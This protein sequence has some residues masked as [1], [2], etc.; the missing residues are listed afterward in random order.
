[1]PYFLCLDID[2]CAESLDDCDD[3]GR[4]CINTYGGYYCLD[5]VER[6]Y[7]SGPVLVPETYYRPYITHGRWWVSRTGS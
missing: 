2:E 4:D 6:E 3:A 1:M 5:D 7:Q